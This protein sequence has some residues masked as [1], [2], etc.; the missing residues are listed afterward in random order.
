[1]PVQIREFGFDIDPSARENIGTA[2]V[3]LNQVFGIENKAGDVVEIIATV[4][5]R[6]AGPLRLFD[7]LRD[8][9]ILATYRQFTRTGTHTTLTFTDY[10]LPPAS[11]STY[12]LRTR[13]GSANDDIFRSVLSVKV[14][15][16]KDP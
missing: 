11:T 7:L 3:I 2:P 9:S 10:P 16:V 4:D 15:D 12:A 14:L 8:G 1:M 13:E 6:A 5:L